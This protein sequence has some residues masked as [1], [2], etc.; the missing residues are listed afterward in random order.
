MENTHRYPLMAFRMSAT[1]DAPVWHK[2]HPDLASDRPMPPQMINGSID[3]VCFQ[4]NFNNY[5]TELRR[6]IEAIPKDKVQS[7]E[8]DTF[9]RETFA[10]HLTIMKMYFKELYEY[11]E[12]RQLLDGKP[13]EFLYMLVDLHDFTRYVI[14]GEYPLD[15]TER[16]SDAV[17]QRIMTEMFGKEVAKDFIPYFHTFRWMIGEVEPPNPDTASNPEKIALILKLIDVVSKGSDGK[18]IDPD[19]IFNKGMS[20]DRWIDYQTEKKRFPLKAFARDKKHVRTI[21]EI[22]ADEYKKRDRDITNSGRYLT[23][24][25]TGV[26]FGNIYQRVREQTIELHLFNH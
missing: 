21:W 8:E 15:Y 11:P 25:L 19:T 23:E 17:E 13:L 24:K 4:T 3:Y 1:L 26:Q 16:V 22:S 10:A 2:K 7:S 12:F 9:N 20:H 18:L 5:T 6:F 14:N